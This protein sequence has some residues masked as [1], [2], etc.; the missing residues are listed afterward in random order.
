MKKQF[1]IYLKQ[2]FSDGIILSVFFSL[3]VSKIKHTV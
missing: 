3:C 2:E 1:S